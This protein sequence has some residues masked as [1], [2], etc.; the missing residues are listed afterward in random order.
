MLE[1]PNLNEKY[2][3]VILFD[4]PTYLD[5]E[6][7][8]A[9]DMFA[10]VKRREIHMNGKT[11]PKPQLIGLFKGSDPPERIFIQCLGY[12]KMAVYKEAPVLCLKCSRWGHMAFKCIYSHRCRYCGR[13]HDSQQCAEKIKNKEKIPRKCCNCG[14]NHNANDWSC[15]KRPSD[16]A[17]LQSKESLKKPIVASAAPSESENVWVR[18]ETERKKLVGEVTGV[19]ISSKSDTV[20]DAN[21][22]VKDLRNEV[23]CLKKLVIDLSQKVSCLTEVVK[24]NE[25]RQQVNAVNE[26]INENVTDDAIIKGSDSEDD[27]VINVNEYDRYNEMIIENVGNED[28]INEHV[29]DDELI[30]SYDRNESVMSGARPKGESHSWKGKKKKENA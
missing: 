29:S 16:E 1:V 24:R 10:W 6:D 8:L 12:K 9:T 25:C 26:I 18:R 13:G 11:E 5:A 14:A 4:Y 22:V 21:D 3:K 17:K 23:E 30:N 27:E 15:P 2:T 20:S 28:M 19:T 7:V